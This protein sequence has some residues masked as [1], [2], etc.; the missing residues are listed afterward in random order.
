MQAKY[1]S[2]QVLQLRTI[3]LAAFY[4]YILCF[5]R[6][7]CYTSTIT[8]RMT[9]G[10]LVMCILNWILKQKNQSTRN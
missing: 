2:K 4:K 3:F 6:Y 9:K 1:G 10:A 5:F 7:M 8:Y